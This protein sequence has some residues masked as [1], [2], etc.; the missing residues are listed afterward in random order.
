MTTRRVLTVLPAAAATLLMACSANVATRHTDATYFAPSTVAEIALHSPVRV[1]ARVVSAGQI[2]TIPVE[3]GE[4][5]DPVTGERSDPAP[6]VFAYELARVS[7]LRVLGA[8]R[9]AGIAP[10]DTLLVG[11]TVLDPTFRPEPGS[12]LATAITKPG[13][14]FGGATGQTGVF[15]LSDLRPLGDAGQGWTVMGYAQYTSPTSATV[16]GTFGPLRGRGVPRAEVAAAA[17]I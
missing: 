17:T 16:R 2:A 5:P 3:P 4:S 15:F 8:P 6:H 1:E 7:V 12:D 9:T 11:V 13:E 14:T 10:G